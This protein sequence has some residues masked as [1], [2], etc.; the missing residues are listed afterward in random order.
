MI[1]K[2]KIKIAFFTFPH[3]V[4]WY[5]QRLLAVRVL[6]YDTHASCKSCVK[7]AQGTRNCKHF[8]DVKDAKNVKSDSL[9]YGASAQLLDLQDTH[10][11]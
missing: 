5:A 6:C 2:A 1:K 4:C 8:L 10:I 3:S 7:S 11:K 9:R